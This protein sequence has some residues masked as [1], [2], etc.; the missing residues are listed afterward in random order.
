[1]SKR[2]DTILVE[3]IILSMRKIE[4]YAKDC[5]SLGEF[6]A[7]YKTVDAVIRNLEIIGEAAHHLSSEFK[8]QNSSIEWIKLVGLR[9]RIVHGYFCVDL[10]I[11]WQI[12]SFDL[13]K[14]KLAL[15]ELHL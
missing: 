2:Q 12:L 5:S 13:K 15:E 4:Q 7:D 6:E 10:S 1:M 3:D 8:E 11:V 9:N 14:L